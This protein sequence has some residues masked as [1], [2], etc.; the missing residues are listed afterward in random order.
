M[1]YGQK[2]STQAKYISQCI[3][4]QLF[5]ERSVSLY[6]ALDQGIDKQCI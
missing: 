2:Q 5:D 3:V 4:A 6:T 1:A